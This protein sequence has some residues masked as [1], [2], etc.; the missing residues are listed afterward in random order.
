[1]N[2]HPWTWGDTWVMTGLIALLI[3]CFVLIGWGVN[4]IMD[5]L[6]GRR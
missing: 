5:I 1:M 3:V 4:R 2:A 6:V